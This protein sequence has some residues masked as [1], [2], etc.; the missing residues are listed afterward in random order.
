M[1]SGP[2]RWAFSLGPAAAAAAGLPQVEQS[3]ATDVLIP[4][5]KDTTLAVGEATSMGFFVWW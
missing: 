5:V 2:I 1:S 3:I 4:K